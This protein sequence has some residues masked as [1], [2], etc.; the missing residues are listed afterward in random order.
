MRISLQKT[1]RSLTKFLSFS[2]NPL[3]RLTF[4]ES[5]FLREKKNIFSLLSRFL[6][7]HRQAGKFLNKDLVFG[8][9]WAV[10]LS[11]VTLCH[12]AIFF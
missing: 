2:F 8:Q 6:P 4:W 11:D 12:F 7:L 1:L 9:G 5:C 3:Y 10:Q